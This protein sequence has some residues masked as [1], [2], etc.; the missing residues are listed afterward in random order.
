M[1]NER[2][3][4]RGGNG[5]W[6][7][8][9]DV[10]TK[11]FVARLIIR[12][13]FVCLST[14]CPV[15]LVC[16][17]VSLC[18]FRGARRRRRRRRRWKRGRE[19]NKKKMRARET[20]QTRYARFRP[21]QEKWSLVRQQEGRCD[22]RRME[23]ER[24][25]DSNLY[26]ITLSATGHWCALILITHKLTRQANVCKQKV[27]LL[28]RSME[29]ALADCA[30][31]DWAARVATDQPVLCQTFCCLRCNRCHNPL[32]RAKWAFCLAT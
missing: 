12:C 20:V 27:L 6:V 4:E 14:L 22:G 9:M 23:K 26:S 5:W 24:E 21:G 8:L 7:T 19:R 1:D 31:S 10:S 17:C 15:C 2:K 25:K 11:W 30:A 29:A 32:D 13:P 28:A 18:V 16:V 3:R